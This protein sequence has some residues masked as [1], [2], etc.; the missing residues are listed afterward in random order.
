MDSSVNRPSGTPASRPGPT[1]EVRQEKAPLLGF[2]CAIIQLWKK[3]YQNISSGGN[4][5]VNADA[6]S[7]R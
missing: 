5:P 4:L 6:V 2:F 7:I 3:D 1:I